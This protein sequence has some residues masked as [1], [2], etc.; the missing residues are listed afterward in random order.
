MQLTPALR[1]ETGLAF[2]STRAL[3]GGAVEIVY[4]VNRGAGELPG[5]EADWAPASQRWG[6]A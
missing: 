1:P 2:E 6:A 3:G 4:A 5:R